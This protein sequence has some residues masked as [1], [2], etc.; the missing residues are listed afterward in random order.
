MVT[1]FVSTIRVQVGMTDYG[2]TNSCLPIFPVIPRMMLDFS[3]VAVNQCP[4]EG[5]LF[6]F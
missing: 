5:Y 2:M 1:I 3:K 4:C 6:E